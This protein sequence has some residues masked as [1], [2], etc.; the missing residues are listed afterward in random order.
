MNLGLLGFDGSRLGR[1]GQLSWE[2]LIQ[3][4]WWGQLG[5]ALHDPHRPPWSGGQPGHCLLRERQGH[6]KAGREGSASAQNQGTVRFPAFLWQKQATW[7]NP[8][9]A[10]GR[11]LLPRA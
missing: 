9:S 5:R 4:A 11:V 7:P 8:S 1:A 3:P 6:E 10:T 2:Q